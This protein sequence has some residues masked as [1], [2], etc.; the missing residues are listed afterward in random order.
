MCPWEMAGGAPRCVGCL[1]PTRSEL[2]FWY[3]FL[4]HRLTCC[5]LDDAVLSALGSPDEFT[6]EQRKQFCD[7]LKEVLSDLRARKIRD[8]DIIAKEVVA[9]R[10]RFLGDSS[11]VLMLEGTSI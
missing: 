6:G 3:P 5:P 1:K 11:K 10:A 8:F 9:H 4:S 7:G 2:N